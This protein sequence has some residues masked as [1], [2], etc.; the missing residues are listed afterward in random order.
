MQIAPLVGLRQS[1]GCHRPAPRGEESVSPKAAGKP[2]A[3]HA[4]WH[5]RLTLRL[6]SMPGCPWLAAE[7][8]RGLTPPIAMTVIKPGVILALDAHE[9]QDRR[10]MERMRVVKKNGRA[11]E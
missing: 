4:G 6:N 9:K 2:G 10:A 5:P 8:R 1:R 7:P 11:A 3:N